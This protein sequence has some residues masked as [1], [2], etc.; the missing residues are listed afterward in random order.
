MH[1]VDVLGVDGDD[2]RERVPDAHLLGHQVVHWLAAVD[3]HG[4]AGH[5]GSSSQRSCAQTTKTDKIKQN[6][7]LQK[8]LLLIRHATSIEWEYGWGMILFSLHCARVM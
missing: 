6:K 3:A 2:E 4:R 8:R 5:G 7:M 1:P